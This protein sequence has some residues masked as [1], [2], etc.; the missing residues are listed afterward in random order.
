[1]PYVIVTIPKSLMAL[2]LC[3]IGLYYC[4]FLQE[5]QMIF[6]TATYVQIK[7]GCSSALVMLTLCGS[8]T[9]VLLS[10]LLI[11]IFIRQSDSTGQ[12]EQQRDVCVRPLLFSALLQDQDGE[13]LNYTALHFSK[14]NRRSERPDEEL[15]SSVQAA[16]LSHSLIYC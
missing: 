10:A 13:M 15:H 9:A 3:C 16:D 11:L 1:M 5:R 2:L 14:R 8:V 12:R 4:S 6:S 7:A